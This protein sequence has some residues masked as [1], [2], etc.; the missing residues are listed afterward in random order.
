[1]AAPDY[2]YKGE[3]VVPRDFVPAEAG[4]VAVGD[5]FLVEAE[6]ME[7]SDAKVIAVYDHLRIAIAMVLGKNK[8]VPINL[9]TLKRPPTLH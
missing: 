7:P 8:F 4:E 9:T 3:Y 5:I 1:M 2:V 6:G